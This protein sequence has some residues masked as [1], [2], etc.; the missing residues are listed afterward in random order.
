MI[1]AAR[2]RVLKRS[3]VASSG[4][5]GGN[6][7]KW[8]HFVKIAT[9]RKV[10]YSWGSMTVGGNGAVWIAILGSPRPRSLWGQRIDWISCG[11]SRLELLLPCSFFVR[12]R[13]RN[14][15]PRMH[16]RFSMTCISVPSRREGASLTRGE[17]PSG[18]DL[19]CKERSCAHAAVEELWTI[20]RKAISSSMATIGRFIGQHFFIGLPGSG[21]NR[22]RGMSCSFSS[23]WAL[24]NSL[25]REFFISIG[26]ARALGWI[27]SASFGRECAADSSKEI[28]WRYRSRTVTGEKETTWSVSISPSLCVPAEEDCADELVAYW[29]I[30]ALLR[31][32]TPAKNIRTLLSTKWEDKKRKK[33]L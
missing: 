31:I 21:I 32:H 29:N 13:R 23:C 14:L 9:R 16:I 20:G 18:V 2:G 4:G 24:R 17:D 30:V 7:T 28:S 6:N 25:A 27:F 15:L 5:L 19:P 12:G 10:H 3:S 8:W 1:H 26:I 33:I 22:N 11:S